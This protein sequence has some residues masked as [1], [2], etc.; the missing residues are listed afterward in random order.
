MYNTYLWLLWVRTLS[1]SNLQICL[2]V[3][4]KLR[5]IWWVN[6]PAGTLIMLAPGQLCRGMGQNNHVGTSSLLLPRPFQY[7]WC[8]PQ[9]MDVLMSWDVCGAARKKGPDCRGTVQGFWKVQWW[10][11]RLT[12]KG[13]MSKQKLTGSHRLKN[14]PKSKSKDIS[15]LVKVSKSEVPDGQCTS[16]SKVSAKVN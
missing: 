4:W 10:Y 15:I 9:T 11:Q 13:S 2:H 14:I 12:G 16:V 6:C 1:T 3:N 5:S 7:I 8:S